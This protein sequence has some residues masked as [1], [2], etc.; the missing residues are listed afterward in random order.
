MLAALS[1]LAI[2]PA[3]RLPASTKPPVS[4]HGT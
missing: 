3:G 4:I 1:L 2:V